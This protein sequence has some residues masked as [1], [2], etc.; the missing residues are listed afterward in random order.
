MTIIRIS[1]NFFSQDEKITIE[2]ND[3]LTSQFTLKEVK[4]AVFGSYAEGGLA[5]MACPS[6]SIKS[7]GT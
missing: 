1:S 3:M 2:E 5:R 6:F 7:I 4:D